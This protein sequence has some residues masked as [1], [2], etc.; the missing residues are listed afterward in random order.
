[1]SIADMDSGFAVL[2]KVADFNHK[3]EVSS[4]NRE[5]NG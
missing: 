2:K 1:M 3:F 5:I 4:S